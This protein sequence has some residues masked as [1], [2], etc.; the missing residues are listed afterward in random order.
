MGNNYTKLSPAISQLAAKGGLPIQVYGNSTEINPDY[1][2]DLTVTKTIGRNGVG[3]K[4]YNF[5]AP[6]DLNQQ[7]LDLGFL[8]PAWCV[9]TSCSIRCTIALVGI[10]DMNM[11]L[12]NVSAGNQF[13]AS[14]S[15]NAL[16]E[17]I[18]QV[19]T[20]PV[21]NA[22]AT[23]IWLG[24]TPVTNTWDLGTAGEWLLTFTY[25]NFSTW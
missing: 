10:A 19:A 11:V 23:K 1:A 17:T 4:D 24:A 3:G 22:I 9:I 16:N 2:P 8:L 5:A 6:A 25:K 14:A 12:G 18:S 15:V 21:I 7:N 13:I 20:L